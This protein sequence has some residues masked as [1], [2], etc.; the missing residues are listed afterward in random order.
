MQSLKLDLTTRLAKNLLNDQNQK[1]KGKNE[2]TQNLLQGRS[3]T[4]KSGAKTST[5]PPSQ[6]I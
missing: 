4:H 1:N 3:T 6:I 5:G 2:K